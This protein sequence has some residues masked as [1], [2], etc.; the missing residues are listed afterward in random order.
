MERT[1]WVGFCVGM[2]GVGLDAAKLCSIVFARSLSLFVDEYPTNEC[3]ITNSRTQLATRSLTRSNESLLPS[4]TPSP[5]YS[6]GR[7]I[8]K[9][10]VVHF[11]L[12]Q[13]SWIYCYFHV[14]ALYKP[15]FLLSQT[16]MTASSLL[17]VWQTAKSE[18][19][20]VISSNSSTGFLAVAWHIRLSNSFKY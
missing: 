1:L 18:V 2:S 20:N 12:E 13:F 7:G 10:C 6:C 4:P 8:S 11:I 5:T 19:P 3:L 17:R 9:G 15:T 14:H 16:F